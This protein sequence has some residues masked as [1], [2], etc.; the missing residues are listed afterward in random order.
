M[1]VV[2]VVVVASS[3]PRSESIWCAPQVGSM[4]KLKQFEIQLDSEHGVFYPGNVIKGKCVLELKA[5]VRIRAIRV[6]IRGSSKVHLRET[7]HATGNLAFHAENINSELVYFCKRK[8][9][10]ASETRPEADQ[11]FDKG[12]HEFEFTFVLP[13]R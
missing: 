2:V 3:S 7:R 11:V 12:V 4:G 6:D 5:D 13:S 8:V 10:F 9:L 1:V